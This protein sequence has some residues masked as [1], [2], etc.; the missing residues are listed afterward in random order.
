M[1]AHRDEVMLLCGGESKSVAGDRGQ[2]IAVV[3]MNI[4]PLILS[5]HHGFNVANVF[6]KC[7]LQGDHD[8]PKKREAVM[9]PF[10]IIN[11]AYS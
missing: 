7:F 2:D 9:P 6:V 5:D 4:I 8:K 1:D 3:R 11:A 10:H